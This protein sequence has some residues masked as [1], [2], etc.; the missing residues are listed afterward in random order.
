MYT[1]PKMRRQVQL[2][3]SPSLALKKTNPSVAS[4]RGNRYFSKIKRV[5]GGR[6]MP[7]ERNFWE[8][9]ETCRHCPRH[10][11]PQTAGMQRPFP[12]TSNGQGGLADATE[13]PSRRHSGPLP[14]RARARALQPHANEK[15]QPHGDDHNHKA[16]VTPV[17]RPP[18]RRVQP[19]LLAQE[20]P[21]RITDFEV[22][23]DDTE[24]H[25]LPDAQVARVAQEDRA[26]DGD[27]HEAAREVEE[28]HI[29]VRV[30]HRHGL[31]DVRVQDKVWGRE[32]RPY[33]GDANGGVDPC[34]EYAVEQ[35]NLGL[36]EWR[37]VGDG[38]NV[39]LFGQIV[40]LLDSEGWFRVK[41]RWC[42]E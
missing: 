32:V 36:P 28:E 4:E 38:R 41:M 17:L 12:G 34:E 22:I 29:V 15:R 16:Q 3:L 20:V 18:H 35:R 8:V 27:G 9:A 39:G 25:N 33:R 31:G 2:R 23:Q 13:T 24:L 7:C 5:R 21:H 14:F 42:F 30:A 37:H 19:A 40:R 1:L 6:N 10:I 11:E 26:H